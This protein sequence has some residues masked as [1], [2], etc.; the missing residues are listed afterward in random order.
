[1]DSLLAKKSNKSTASPDRSRFGGMYLLGVVFCLLA[2]ALVAVQHNVRYSLRDESLSLL[3]REELIRLKSEAPSNAQGIRCLLVTEDGDATSRKAKGVYMPV[4]EQMREAYDTCS[5][6]DLRAETLGQYARIVLAVTHYAKLRE[7][8]ADIRSWVRDGGSLMIAY[9]PEVSGNFETLYTTLGIIGSGEPALVEG[10]HFTRDFMIG[11]QARVY[12]IMDAYESSLSLSLTDDC[13]VYLESTGE[14]P[15]PLIWRRTVG[16]GTVVVDNFG[17]MEKA[18]RGIHC[19]AYS[20]LG[21]YCA[22]PVI[23]GAAFFIDDF[24]SPV[25]EGDAAYITRDYNVSISDFYSRIWW[26]DIYRLGNARGIRFTGLV[27]EDYSDQVSGTFRRNAETGRFLYFGNLLLRSGGEIG[28]HG[29][30]HMPLVLENFD[31]KDQYD[32]YVHWPSVSDMRRSLDEV[33]AFTHGLFPDESLQV[34]VPP[35]NVL[36]AEG[37][38]LLGDTSVRS[39]AAVYFPVDMSYE[40][41]FDVSAADGIINTPRI[42][43]GCVIDDYMKIAALSELNLHL[44]NTHFLHPDD[45]LDEDR[46]AALGWKTL[47]GNLERYMDWLYESYPAIRN[48]T[49]SELAAAVQRYDLLGVSRE[50]SGDTIHLS[51]DRLTDEAWMLLRVNDGAQIGSVSGGSFRAVADGLYLIECRS[52]TVEIHLEQGV[53]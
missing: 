18:Y 33:F 6:S 52:D 8:V 35:S 24:P 30:N 23:N 34:Y 4:L 5:V 9:P 13:A 12:A 15:I 38:G 17:I 50:R 26:N 32:S 39:I 49:G 31:Y 51:L 22:Y 37:R 29:Y 21:D 19:A 46:G 27:I 43:S 7:T 44:V 11:A 2:A 48:L 41:E 40:Q 20:L 16:R 28:I 45:V 14:Y 10:I 36:S 3:P 25:P 53:S 47:F 1:M 42:T